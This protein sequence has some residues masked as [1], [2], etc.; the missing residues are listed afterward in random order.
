LLF[1]ELLLILILSGSWSHTLILFALVLEIYISSGSLELFDLGRLILV[2]LFFYWFI[3]VLLDCWIL[4][5]N[6]GTAFI[7]WRA[8]VFTEVGSM[9]F[10][11]FFLDIYNGLGLPLPALALE[12]TLTRCFPNSIFLSYI[13]SISGFS[14]IFDITSF[15]CLMGLK[16]FL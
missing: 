15:P 9:V 3:Q 10:V 12:L 16:S 14:D 4:K 8:A 1:H 2:T 6:T 11:I 5:A 7:R 13:S